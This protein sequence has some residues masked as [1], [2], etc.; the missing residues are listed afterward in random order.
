MQRRRRLMASLCAA[1]ALATASPLHAAPDVSAADAKAVRGV[2]EAQLAAFAADDADKAFSYAAPGIRAMFVT[3]ERFLAMVREG[4]PVVY[5][6]AS[7]T[8]LK[9]EWIQDKLIQRVQMTDA[10]G[11][12]WMVVYEVERQADR[13][14][15]IAA[16]VAARGA[17]RTT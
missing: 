4:Y 16:C 14:W 12:P 8:F 13:S 7:V 2:I 10:A 3:A 11:A 9:P 6:P 5:R 1:L 15:R 17:G